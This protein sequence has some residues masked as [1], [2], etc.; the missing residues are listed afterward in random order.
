MATAAQEAHYARMREARRNKSV[1]PAQKLMTQA[2]SMERNVSD[3]NDD[4]TRESGM[5]VQVQ[6]TAPSRVWVWVLTPSGSVR[7]EVSVQSLGG[8]EGMLHNPTVSA[9]CWDCGRDDCGEDI[10]DCTGRPKRKFR[11]C[12][13]AT[14]RKRVY[15]PLPTGRHIEGD[16]MTARPNEQGSDEGEIDDDAYANTTV[17]VRTKVALDR[18]IIGYHEQEAITFGLRTPTLRDMRTPLEVA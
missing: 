14:C 3:Y 7:R 13:V 12:P 18:H 10:N 2:Y 11:T 16:G 15:D 9:V 8:P 4:D 6:H 17:E 1:T 5:P